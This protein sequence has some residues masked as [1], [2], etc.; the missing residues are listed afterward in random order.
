MIIF[1]FKANLEEMQNLKFISMVSK[2]KL[3]IDLEKGSLASI[4]VKENFVH[5]LACLLECRVS[6]WPLTY[7]GL[8]LVGNP[9]V[10][11]FWDSIL[12]LSIRWLKKVFLSLGGT[13][14]LMHLSLNLIY[15]LLVFKVLVKVAS[16]IEKMCRT[17]FGQDLE[18]E[19]ETTKLIGN[20]CANPKGWRYGVGENLLE[21][22]S[23][24]R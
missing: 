14:T 18:K 5:D 12:D 2:S 8:P 11:S 3:K 10:V 4:D 22:Y 21:N 16:R 17:F 1:F 23:P 13:T 15:F 7:L 19:R 9:R 20:M 6:N 24:S